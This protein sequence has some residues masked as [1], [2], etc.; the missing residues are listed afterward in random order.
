[1]KKP[2]NLLISLLSLSLLVSCSGNNGSTNNDNDEEFQFDEIPLVDKPIEFEDK[3]DYYCN[4][5]YDVDPN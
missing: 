4:Q 5:A 2:A 1:M 3:S